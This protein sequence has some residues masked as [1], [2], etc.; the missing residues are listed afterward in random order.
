MLSSC[1]SNVDS[2]DKD[3]IR[4]LAGENIKLRQELA[5]LKS[6]CNTLKADKEGLEQSLELNILSK[7]EQYNEISKHHMELVNKVNETANLQKLIKLYIPFLIGEHKE[8]YGG[9]IYSR[10][11]SEG[12]DKF[13]SLLTKENI[14]K[15][16]NITNSLISLN[17]S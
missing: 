15:I 3:K 14:E 1:N 8:K 9:I 16:D 10:I 4:R 5:L 2:N 17:Y 13:I 7:Q 11:Q 12:I 6:E